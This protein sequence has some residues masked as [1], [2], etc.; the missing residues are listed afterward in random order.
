MADVRIQESGAT[1]SE[2]F[3]RHEAGNWTRITS[4][5]HSTSRS[6]EDIT[7]PPRTPPSGVVP[8]PLDQG[9]AALPHS[10][11]ASLRQT[12][13]LRDQHIYSL[14]ILLTLLPSPGPLS[15]DADSMA[16]VLE[17]VF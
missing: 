3:I 14:L 7:H 17:G 16:W 10:V 1:S 2:F 11:H 6:R 12:M 8:H 13:M 9:T 15:Q 5:C 4:T